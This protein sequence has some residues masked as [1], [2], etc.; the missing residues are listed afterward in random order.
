MTTNTVKVE[1]NV[2]RELAERVNS[3]INSLGLTPT[4]LI[5]MVYRTID[6]TGTLP[7][8]AELTEE[9]KS[10]LALIKASEKVPIVHVNTPEDFDKIM[11]KRDDD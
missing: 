5:N 7:I 2:D 11:G 10:S 6:N 3:T 1:A 8:Q 4:T 9:Q